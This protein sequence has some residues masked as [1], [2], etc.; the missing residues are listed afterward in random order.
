MMPGM[1]KQEATSLIGRVALWNGA[2]YVLVNGYD[3]ES[4]SYA[5]TALERPEH[6][7]PAVVPSVVEAVAVEFFPPKSFAK[8]FP[9]P[10]IFA[11]VS[12]G[13]DSNLYGSILDISNG[14]PE[15]LIL[16]NGTIKIDTSCM[17]KGTPPVSPNHERI[18]PVTCIDY[19]LAVRL[20]YP[21][22]V[23]EFEDIH[24]CGSVPNSC[25]VLCTA[26]KTIVFRR[27]RLSSPYIAAVHVT[28]LPEN[29]I[30][31][32]KLPPTHVKFENCEFTNCTSP[33]HRAM[34]VTSPGHVLLLNCTFHNNEGGSITV[35][36]GG[37]VVVKHCTF[38]DE[39]GYTV[40]VRFSILHV[41]QN[42]QPRH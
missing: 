17:V 33:K 6:A 29:S 1:S 42:Q 12:M 2:A 34:H 3:K 35:D 13:A 14:F 40:Y 10:K 25:C 32:Q 4:K 9:N 21:N 20:K 41:H 18:D 16:P 27:C 39:S 38:R 24:F 11:D 15:N 8:R 23:A 28:N 5:V 19:P 31:R 36:E 22:D 30:S 7:S 37:K 26:G